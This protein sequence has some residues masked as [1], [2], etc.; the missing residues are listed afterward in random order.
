MRK[1]AQSLLAFVFMNGLALFIVCLA[2][3][4]SQFSTS[5]IKQELHTSTV[6]PLIVKLSTENLEQQMKNDPTTDESTRVLAM[7]IITKELTPE[8]FQGKVDQFIDVAEGYVKGTTTTVPTITFNDLRDK[9]LNGGTPP[10]GTTDTTIHL[11][12]QLG[13]LRQ[14]YYWYFPSYIL[15]GILTVISFIL[16]IW[17]S[18]TTISRFKAV[19]H[20]LLSTALFVFLPFYILDKTMNGAWALLTQKYPQYI[21]LGRPI[22]DAIFA[23][24]ISEFFR[25]QN[26]AMVVF[27]IGAAACYAYAFVLHRQEKHDDEQKHQLI[28]QNSVNVAPPQ[29]VPI[30]P[31]GVQLTNVVR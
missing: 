29:P 25:L 8:Y 14:V 12:K 6:Y 27:F 2:F 9:I 20:V 24:V 23:P 11:E 7:Q 28:E 22:Y 21:E 19:G 16:I 5:K 13:V 10:Q 4:T 26:T 31:G 3:Q 1:F 30:P 18:P 17:I 15:S